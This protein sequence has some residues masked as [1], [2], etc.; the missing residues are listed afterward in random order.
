MARLGSCGQRC[1][2]KPPTKGNWE[3]GASHKDR[4]V[5]G[6]PQRGKPPKVPFA[7]EQRGSW[8][9]RVWLSGPEC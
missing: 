2:L 3:A 8:V 9:W 6:Y 7:S 1:S 4:T 5:G